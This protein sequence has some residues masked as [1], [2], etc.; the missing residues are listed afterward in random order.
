MAKYAVAM[1]RTAS[2]VASLGTITSSAT[3]RRTKIYDMIFGSQASPADNVFQYIVTRCTAPG[4]N[5][6][7]TPAPLDPAD[8]AA[9]TVVG[10]LNTV[11]PTGNTPTLLSVELNQRATLRWVAAPGSELVTPATASNG[12]GIQTPT[13]T[14]VAITLSTMFEE[15]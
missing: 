6:A 13:A 5:S 2:T 10:Q 4:T 7:V 14:A 15:Q 11:E 3:V 9:L 8:A 1:T 12:V